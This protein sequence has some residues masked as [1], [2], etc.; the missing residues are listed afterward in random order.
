MNDTMQI[1]PLIH[2]HFVIELLTID[3]IFD[4]ITRTG[5]EETIINIV[6]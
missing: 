5:L 3:K 2:N 6:T 1:R 4:S